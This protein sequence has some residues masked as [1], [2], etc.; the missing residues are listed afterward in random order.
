[1]VITQDN[2][3]P[4]RYL[5]KGPPEYGAG[6][7]NTRPRR[8]FRLC[9]SVVKTQT[10]Y[11]AVCYMYSRLIQWHIRF[12]RNFKWRCSS[13]NRSVVWLKF[14]GTKTFRIKRLNDNA[15]CILRIISLE[16][17]YTGCRLQFLDWIMF[18]LLSAVK[19]FAAKPSTPFLTVL[20]RHWLSGT[21]TRHVNTPFWVCL[22]HRFLRNN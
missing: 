5:N 18:L 19:L 3:S 1:M 11:R 6:I 20:L 13:F 15:A 9:N 17:T 8:S 22:T 14:W 10:I 4:G 16:F 21:D 2:R 12:R 7:L